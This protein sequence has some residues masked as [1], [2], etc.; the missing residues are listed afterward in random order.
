MPEGEVM[1]AQVRKWTRTA[2]GA[3]LAAALLAA[4]TGHS[5]EQSHSVGRAAAAQGELN[6]NETEETYHEKGYVYLYRYEKCKGGND[7]K[8]K[9]NDNGYGD[10]KGDI[11]EFDNKAD[12][13]VNTTKSHVKFYNYPNYNKDAGDK[14]DS[15]CL[16]PGEWINR[17]QYYGDADGSHDWWKNSISSHRKVKSSSCSR[18]FGWGSSRSGT[19]A[20]G[21]RDGGSRD[22]KLD[23]ETGL[24]YNNPDDT[25]RVEIVEHIADLIRGAEEGSDITVAA[26]FFGHRKI[27]RAL[28]DMAE[29]TNI[30]VIVDGGVKLAPDEDDNY[31][32]F[33]ELQSEI[34]GDPNTGEW[35]QHCG[36]GPSAH[37]ACIGTGKMHNKFFLFE[38]TM[39]VDN[40]V[41]QTSANLKEGGSGTGMWNTSYTAADDGLYEHYM[42]YFDDL[43][44]GNTIP[45][46]YE[47][48]DLP[49]VGGKYAIYHSPRQ[50]GNTAMDLLDKV[51]CTKENDTGGTS[52]GHRTIVRVAMWMISGS[53]WNSTGTKLARKLKYMDDQGCYVDVVANTFGKGKGGNDGALEALLRKPKGKFHGPEVR[54]FYNPKGGDRAG[55]HS[56]DI[57]ID[58]YYAG[59]KNQ[60]VVITGTYNLTKTSVVSNDETVLVI[61]DAHL[62]DD[63]TKFHFAVRMAASLTWQTS[64]FKR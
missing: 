17:L 59:K 35:I 63:F 56:K 11:E 32:E 19:A 9:D 33:Y 34:G 16:G 1:R 40:V 3:G 14:G 45:N 20:G 53:T 54:E 48:N 64:K 49:P 52:P 62:H 51:D 30:R 8:D 6:C 55:L 10:G 31:D 26:H 42:A 25:S 18:W 46:Y 39:G 7:A 4:C 28:S 27:R 24:H 50:G 13:I 43:E 29:D 2:I 57:L 15:F 60:K 23:V 58:G 61:K 37:R 41:V 12:S 38:K 44:P 47:D 36:L 21:A 22:Q 5:A